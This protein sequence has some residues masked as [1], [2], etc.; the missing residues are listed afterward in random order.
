MDSVAEYSWGRVLKEKAETMTHVLE[1]PYNGEPNHEFLMHDP[2]TPNNHHFVRNHGGIPK[3]INADKYEVEIG[4]KVKKK[5]S[6]K[7]SDLRDPAKFP[8]RKLEVTLQCC[9]TRRCEQIALYPG[10][11]LVVPNAPWPEGAIGNA[12][13]TGVYLKD[14]LERACEGITLTS[15]Q[16]HAEFISADTYFKFNQL[17]NYA[18]SV[19]Y[20]FV[21]KENVMLAWDMNGKVSWCGP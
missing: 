3:C 8:Q 9:G 15:M 14:V 16:A 17:Y 19:P 10:H 11:G 20:R 13:Y 6:L 12:V 5:V 1:F 21:E 2:I 7:L 4:G 18:V